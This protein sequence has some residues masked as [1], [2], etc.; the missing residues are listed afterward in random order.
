MRWLREQVEN[1]PDQSFLNGYSYKQIYNQA[2][3]LVGFL[4]PTIA[5]RKR[6]GV[7]SENSLQLAIVLFALWLS[8]KEVFLINPQL[9]VEER[10]SQA[11]ELGVDLVF[12][13]P[14]VQA[15]VVAEQEA[16]DGE[17]LKVGK[18]QL[19]SLAGCVSAA[20]AQIRFIEGNEEHLVQW[21]SIP[22]LPLMDE[23]TGRRLVALFEQLVP[24]HEKVSSKVITDADDDAIAA[25]MTTSATTGKVKAVPLRWGQIE[26]HVKASAQVLGVAPE[27]NWLI[28]LPMFHVSGLSILMRTLYNGTAAT[29]HSGFDEDAVLKAIETGKINMM[30]LVPTVLQRLVNK[31]K[32]HQLRVILL[33]G[34]FIPNALVEA[35]LAKQL[36]IFKT[37]GMTETFAQSTTVDIL[38]YPQKWQSVGKPLPGVVIEIRPLHAK[39]VEDSVGSLATGATGATRFTEDEIGE[40]WISSPMVMKGYL[41]QAPIQGFFNTDDMGYVDED[42]F[43]YIVNRRKDIIIS[44]GENIYPKEI[45]DVLYTLDGIREC[46]VVPKAD[47]KW[48]QVPVLYYAGAADPAT[49]ESH[50]RR[51]LGRYKQPKTIHKLEALPRNSS[52]KILR[53]ALM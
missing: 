50:L 37:Y 29:I 44:G 27:D 21:Q 36:P 30:S 46:A 32:H 43:L 49:V 33:G 19:C 51:H 17:Q 45:E 12:T 4:N 6:I 53:R 42:G 14:Q 8:G 18:A 25:I 15:R 26:A 13:S 5:K 22:A 24:T 40:I 28:V 52:G 11:V 10:M 2:I 23:Q 39:G 48:G 16:A 38:K 35:C 41:G 34:E 20:L 7:C 1:R 31:I 9:S 3:L 47:E